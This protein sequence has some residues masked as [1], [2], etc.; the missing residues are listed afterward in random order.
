M[1]TGLN[2]YFFR[3]RRFFFFVV[4]CFLLLFL[5]LF[6]LQII[7]GRYFYQISEGNRRE[8]YFQS[9]PRGIIYDRRGKILA[10]N[11]PLSVLFLSHR[12]LDKETTGDTVKRLSRLL[13]LDEGGFQ[14]KIANA[15]QN[16]IT[17]LKEDISREEIFRLEENRTNLPGM[18]L[19][20]ELRRRYPLGNLAAHLLGYLGE[21]NKNELENLYLEGYRQGDILGKSGLECTYDRFLRGEPGGMEIEVNAKG[22]QTRIIR[23]VPPRA[24]KSIYLTI[25]E[26]LQRTCEEE[27]KS[28]KKN[29][30]I[31][32][33]DP[34]N[35][36]VLALVS[37]PTYDPNLF[38]GLR[39][40]EDIS[41]L[42]HDQQFPFFNRAIQGRYAPGSIFK[43]ITAICALE[44]GKINLEEEFYCPGYFNL[45]NRTFKCWKTEGH[46]R[47]SFKDALIQSCDVFF[48]QLGLRCGVDNLE[49]Y[50]KKFA[51]ND[52]TQ[53]D[54]PGE[55]KGLV[56][57][58]S[59]KRKNYRE[60]WY[61]GDT[62]NLSIGQ[63]YVLITP[64][65]AANLAALV[66]NH[67]KLYQPH[68][69]KKIVEDENTIWEPEQK[70]VADLEISA[71]TWQIFSECLEK[72]VS[73]GTGKAAYL[74]GIEIAG[75]TGTAENP[76]GE[77]HAWFIGY[78]P[79][80]NPR[81]AFAIFVE[82]GGRGGVAA[83]P[84]AKKIVSVA[85]GKSTGETTSPPGAYE[86]SE[87]E[88]D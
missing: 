74:P 64:L 42:L 56:P 82:H 63:G 30:A 62:V 9:Q 40:R 66:A 31:V 36:E 3:L 47:L 13:N 35:G 37:L 69:V 48:Y 75:K 7:R 77:D 54:L 59:W 27:L 15:R 8:F 61:E 18:N 44:E 17:R 65:V 83:A 88:S 84:L 72:A 51:L 67:G 81:V 60:S 16:L 73:E 49:R 71:G 11:G 45:G 32:V 12:G 41:R 20:I 26:E 10:D 34:T 19:Q 29:G 55:K 21:I 24:G 6:Y 68:L 52:L 76:L 28:R 58:R 5:S 14:E 53:I 46:G 1:G 33:I 43:I 23:E 4:I 86:L 25:D 38:S 87:K 79:A 78:A 39:D 22:I 50:A 85:L 70:K 80:E 57:G 2:T